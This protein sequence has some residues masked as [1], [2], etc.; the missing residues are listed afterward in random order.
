[1]YPQNQVSRVC[2]ICV[3]DIQEGE[4]M[5]DLFREESAKQNPEFRVKWVHL[6]CAKTAIQTWLKKKR[7]K[8]TKSDA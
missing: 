1:M 5:L 2:E 6:T 4:V 3:R 8:E 7:D